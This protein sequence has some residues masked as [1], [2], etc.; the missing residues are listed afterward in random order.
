MIIRLV[1]LL[2][3]VVASGCAT[4]TV[5][6]HPDIE[7]H[8]SRLDSVVVAPP[9]VSIRQVNFTGDNERLVEVEKAIQQELI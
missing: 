1:L 7:S 4:T 6:E 5:R 9:A 3:M 8:L 2:S